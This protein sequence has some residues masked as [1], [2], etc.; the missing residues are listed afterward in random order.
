MS[1]IHKVLV[2]EFKKL[3]HCQ[4][5]IYGKMVFSEKKTTVRT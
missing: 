5:T 1:L 3:H 2:K 4:Q